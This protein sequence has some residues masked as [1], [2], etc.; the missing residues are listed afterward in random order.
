MPKKATTNQNT[1]AVFGLHHGAFSFVII[2]EQGHLR[3]ETGRSR[4]IIFSVN[5]DTVLLAT[6]PG[7]SCLRS[8]VISLPRKRCS[9]PLTFEVTPISK[10][11]SQYVPRFISRSAYTKTRIIC[12]GI[13]V[14]LVLYV[15]ARF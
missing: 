5:S 15:V 12:T 11:K 6:T 7:Y 1:K 4:S 13:A 9:S 14:M 10:A 3:Y 2:S 8:I